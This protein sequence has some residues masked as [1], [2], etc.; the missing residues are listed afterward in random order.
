VCRDHRNVERG[1]AHNSLEL[2]MGGVFVGIV[3]G[4]GSMYFVVVCNRRDLQPLS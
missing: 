3:S 1:L 2:D 4:E